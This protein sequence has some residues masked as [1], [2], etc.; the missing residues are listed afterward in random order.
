MKRVEGFILLEIL[1]A[2]VIIVSAMSAVIYLTKLG[3]EQYE[4]VENNKK[5]FSTLPIVIG[6]LESLSIQDLL[7]G[8]GG[9]DTGYGKLLWESK[10]LDSD[11]PVVDIDMTGKEI[12]SKFKHY[13]FKVKISLRFHNYSYENEIYLTKYEE[14]QKDDEIFP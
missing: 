13:L 8:K 1:V 12:H 11:S 5:I 14:T 10:L 6:Y 9:Y 7:N 2:G 3:I 4:K